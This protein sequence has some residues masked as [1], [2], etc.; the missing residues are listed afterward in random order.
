MN[1]EQWFKKLTEAI[2]TNTVIEPTTRISE[3][4]NWDS[5]AIMSVSQMIEE[6]LGVSVSYE[7]INDCDT[8]QDLTQLI[9]QH[10]QKT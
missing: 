3:I 7:K 5:I 1:Q 10:L 9:E 2:K 6:Q 8:V 4:E